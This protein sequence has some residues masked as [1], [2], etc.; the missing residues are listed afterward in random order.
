MWAPC[1]GCMDMDESK[2]RNSIYGNTLEEIVI[3]VT[4]KAKVKLRS[5]LMRSFLL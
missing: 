1:Q 2:M 3:N 4:A 5:F